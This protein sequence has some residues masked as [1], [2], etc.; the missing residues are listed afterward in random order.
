M[1]SAGI[2]RGEPDVGNVGLTAEKAFDQQKS[3]SHREFLGIYDLLQY[4][5]WAKEP[6]TD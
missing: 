2:V 4:H 1:V 5:S 3:I 6:A